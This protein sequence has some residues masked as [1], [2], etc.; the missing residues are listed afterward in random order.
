MKWWGGSA[1]FR[2][3]GRGGG[4][5]FFSQEKENIDSLGNFGQLV[6]QNGLNSPKSLKTALCVRF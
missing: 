6:A 1:F 5:P 4:T 3:K 2:R